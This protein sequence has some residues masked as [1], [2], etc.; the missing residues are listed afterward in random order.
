MTRTCVV[1]TLALAGLVGWST[2]ADAF[3]LRLRCLRLVC[4]PVVPCGVTLVGWR[5][6]IPAPPPVVIPVPPPMQ[7]PPM[8]PP[9][10]ASALPAAP[11][12]SV[13]SPL[14]LSGPGPIK[15][16][17]GPLVNPRPVLRRC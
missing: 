9:V 1:F 5:V 13:P 7:V 6:V 16:V 15:V 17:S 8:P 11:I 14:P 12:V 3:C 10:P 2:Q 4:R